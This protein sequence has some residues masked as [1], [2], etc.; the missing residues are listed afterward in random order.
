L[1][2]SIAVSATQDASGP[3][4]GTLAGYIAIDGTITGLTNH[5][6]ALGT[7]RLEAFPTVEEGSTGVLYTA[8]HPAGLDLANLI[9]DYEATADF[10]Q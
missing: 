3:L 1:G 9:E 7:S 4:R 2:G 10:H 6:V 5:H 8:Y